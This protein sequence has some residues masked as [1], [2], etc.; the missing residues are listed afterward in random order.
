MTITRQLYLVLILLGGFAAPLIT[1]SAANQKLAE[2][3]YAR[4]NGGHIV[5]G[6]NQRWVLWRVAGGYLLEDHFQVPLDAKAQM[7]AD[8]DSKRSSPQLKKKMETEARANELQM[9]F[10]AEF[11]PQQLVVRGNRLLDGRAVE[12]VT[13]D[14][15]DRETLCTGLKGETRLKSKSPRQFFYSFPFPMLFTPLVRQQGNES[16]RRKIDLIALTS[17]SVPSGPELSESEGELS[18]AGQESL[19]LRTSKP[20]VGKYEI[21]IVSSSGWL[22]KATVWASPGGLVMAMERP[23]AKE[24]MELIQYK[25]YGDF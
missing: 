23:G 22:L 5:E 19:S 17:K 6:S 4:I 18:Y 8:L 13:C 1:E 16:G 2:G 12:I 25:K 15:Q 7:L 21:T 9:K 10:S 20:A 11:R 3:E 24:R 14:I